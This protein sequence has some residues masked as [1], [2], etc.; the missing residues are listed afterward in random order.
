M[1][2]VLNSFSQIDQP[3]NLPAMNVVRFCKVLSLGFNLNT[4]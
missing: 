4:F 2:P 3:N 1:D